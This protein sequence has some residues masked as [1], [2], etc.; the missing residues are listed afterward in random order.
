MA[1]PEEMAIS[2]AALTLPRAAGASTQPAETPILIDINTK[3]ENM[4][5]RFEEYRAIYE[6]TASLSDRRQ[7]I[8]NFFAGINTLFLTAFGYLLIT[9]HYNSWWAAII[10]FILTVP[11]T[12]LNVG[13]LRLN[14]RYRNLAAVRIAYLTGL[15][16]YLASQGFAT[17]RVTPPSS[18]RHQST[19]PVDVTGV[20]HFESDAL[21]NIPKVG[22][23]RIE[24]S[25]IWTFLATYG[26]I[27]IF[28]FVLNI[29]NAVGLVTQ[30]PP[31][32]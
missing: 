4:R 13:W 17:F 31:I 7:N 24:Q 19:V 28:V 12:I 9:V 20:H 18:A 11:V 21:Y 6:N 32:R 5:L 25:I 23:S 27:T 8:N 15:E 3:Q 16:E 2:P 26:A 10:F 22:F 14:H 30:I 29:L 1:E